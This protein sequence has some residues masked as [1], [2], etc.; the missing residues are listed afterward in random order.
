MAAARVS[1]HGRLLELESGTG[2]ERGCSNK[3]GTFFMAHGVLPGSTSS[4]L[5]ISYTMNMN[6]H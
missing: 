4:K 5:P 2:R 1:I 3:S 6:T